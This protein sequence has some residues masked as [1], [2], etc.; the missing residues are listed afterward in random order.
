MPWVLAGRFEGLEIKYLTP[1]LLHEI[2]NVHF[3]LIVCVME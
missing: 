1:S 3:S 2:G